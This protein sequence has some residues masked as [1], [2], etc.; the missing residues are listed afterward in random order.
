MLSAVGDR[1]IRFIWNHFSKTNKSTNPLLEWSHE[2]ISGLSYHGK[3]LTKTQDTKILVNFKDQNKERSNNFKNKGNSLISIPSR[4]VLKV[5]CQPF[6][7]T[8]ILSS[9]PSHDQSDRFVS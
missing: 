2:R 1:L 7:F 6:E 5:R 8:T 4:I 9:F 3:T